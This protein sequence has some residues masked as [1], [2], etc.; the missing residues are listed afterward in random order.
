MSDV[1]GMS[2]CVEES[3]ADALQ[4]SAPFRSNLKSCDTPA[5]QNDTTYI[6]EEKQC[7]GNTHHHITQ[8]GSIHYCSTLDR[9]AC[10][11]AALVR[12]SVRSG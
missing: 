12:M 9:S 10:P 11:M 6:R 1:V 8:E 5:S 3:E 7:N 2:G 4:N